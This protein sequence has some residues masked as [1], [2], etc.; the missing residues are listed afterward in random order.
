MWSEWLIF[1]KT[2]L[3]QYKEYEM[4]TTSI[5][6]HN[7]N[8]EVILGSYI[9]STHCLSLSFSLFSVSILKLNISLSISGENL[10]NP[11]FVKPLFPGAHFWLTL[12][13]FW[14]LQKAFFF[15]LKHCEA[16]YAG[17]SESHRSCTS[18]HSES[19]FLLFR[20]EENFHVVLPLHKDV[21]PLLELKPLKYW[22]LEI[23]W[24]ARKLSKYLL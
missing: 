21:S 4:V 15:K 13:Q 11:I 8:F 24:Y 2:I 3:C 22:Q 20:E 18:E 5:T 10:S 16:K 7:L 6:K 1:S 19:T 17:A 12:K 14:D 9:C 23:Y